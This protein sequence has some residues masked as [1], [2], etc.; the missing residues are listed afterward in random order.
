MSRRFI[1]LLLTI[2]ALLQTVLKP[3]GVLGALELPVLTGLMVCIALQ[4]ER[5]QGLDSFF[6]L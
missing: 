5:P 4:T 2:G 1:T 3:G 6:A